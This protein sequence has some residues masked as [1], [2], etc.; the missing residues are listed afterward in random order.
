[1]IIPMRIFTHDFV[2]SC[3]ALRAALG[4]VALIGSAGRRRGEGLS[5]DWRAPRR[6]GI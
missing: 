2:A 6:R 3:K 5:R 4:A 1:M